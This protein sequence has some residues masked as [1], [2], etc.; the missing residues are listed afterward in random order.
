MAVARRN[1]MLPAM[2]RVSV[3]LLC[4]L[5]LFV[6]ACTSSSDGA[7]STSTSAQSPVTTLA[8]TPGA[9]TTSTTDPTVESTTTTAVPVPVNECSVSADSSVDGYAVACTVL[10]IAL[11]GADGMD[12]A[13][14]AQAD[15]VFHMLVN[16]TD[17]LAAIIEAELEGRVIPS[18]QR[19]TALPEY[20]DLYDQYPGTDWRRRGRSFPA[21]ELLPYFSGAEENLLCQDDDFYEGEDYFV[22]TFAQTIRRFALDVVDP[23]TSA[24]IEQAYGQAIAQGLWTNTLAEINE[25]E[26]WM[27]GVQSFFDVNIEDT[28]EDREPNSSHNAVNTREELREYDPKLWAIVASVFGDT[29]WRPTC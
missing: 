29:D 11:R 6:A 1:R 21:T 8:P 2:V 18:D 24:A 27:E 3:L 19:I 22:R 5:A 23:G 26:Y 9:T 4:A 13:V 14:V 7:S 17:L 10:G 12:A 28:A 25:D 15:R 20:A 16:R